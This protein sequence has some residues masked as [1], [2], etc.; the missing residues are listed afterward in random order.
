VANE[1]ELPDCEL[2][3]QLKLKAGERTDTAFDFL[4]TLKAFRKQVAGEVRHIVQ[5]FPEYTPH[6]EE[7]HLTRLFHAADKLLEKKRLTLMNSGELMILALGLYGHD[8][9][10]AVSE[11]QKQC[12]LRGRLV[13]G[14]ELRELWVSHKEV[15]WLENFAH[16]H[17]IAWD[18]Y[19]GFSG[20]DPRLWPEYVR[21]THA[22][23]SGERIRR[24]FEGCDD[25]GLGHQAGR[26]CEAHCLSVEELGHPLMYPDRVGVLDENVNLRAIALYVRLVDLLDLSAGR[27]PYVIWEYVAPRDPRSKIEWEKHRAVHSVTFP[28]GQEGRAVLVEGSTADHEVYAALEDLKRQCEDELRWCNKILDRMKDPRHALQL[29]RVDWSVSAQG[30]DPVSIRFEFDRGAMFDILSQE[31]YQ[32][33]PYVFLRE[34]LQNSVDAIRMRRAVLA[35]HGIATEDFGLVTV[36]V[37]EEHDGEVLVTWRDDGIGMDEHIVRDYLAVAGKSY[38][39]SADFEREDLPMDPIA[40][41]GIGILSCFMVA[42]RVEIETC[43][44]PYFLAS[45]DALR[46][47]IPSTSRQFRVEKIRAK[48]A[49]VGTTVRVFVSEGKLSSPEIDSPRSLRITEYLSAVAGFVEFPISVSEGGCRTIVVHPRA[50]AAAVRKRF[51]PEVEVRQ[52]NTGYDW[53]K[54][55]LP[56]YLQ[57]AER[58]MREVRWDLAADLN[59]AG[60]EGTLSYLVPSEAGADTESASGGDIDVRGIEFVSRGASADSRAVVRWRRPA[61]GRTRRPSVQGSLTSSHGQDHSTYRDGILLWQAP[62]P[63]R[64][65]GFGLEDLPAPRL[66]TN[67][68]RSGSRR[69]DL[70]RSRFVPE[71]HDWDE[72]IADA[73]A[74][75]VVEESISKLLSLAPCDRLYELGRLCLFHRL[76]AKRLWELFPQD[77]WPL[78]FLEHGGQLNALEWQRVRN[79]PIQLCPGLLRFES[80]RLLALRW[81]GLGKYR[82]PLSAWVGDPMLIRSG[83][84]LLQTSHGVERAAALWQFPVKEQYTLSGVRFLNPPWDGDPPLVAKVLSPKSETQEGLGDEAL[85]EQVVHN[86]AD[87]GA[88]QLESLH[89]R[90]IA[91]SLRLGSIPDGATFPAPYEDRFAY[92]SE[93]LNL[94]HPAAVFLLRFV[95]A[96]ELHGRRGVLGA[97]VLAGASD[98]IR[99]AFGALPV[100]RRRHEAWLHEA[101][102]ELVGLSP[103]LALPE[104]PNPEDILVTADDFVPGTA[105]GSASL[106]R[107][108]PGDGRPFGQLIAC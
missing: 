75:R 17:R 22:V 26:V 38:Y 42:D 1:R 96:L 24:F 58:L 19:E 28:A 72:A 49:A 3:N 25:Q 90:T 6:D 7:H 46:I 68:L 4:G 27:A 88:L 9:G 108:R 91:G 37:E 100:H 82:G 101:M 29:H 15:G 51:G 21:E 85:L 67:F 33:D 47:T 77:Y 14:S 36:E 5:V 48:A 81:L 63:H 80:G 73:H 55:F 95:A 62:A 79:D 87:L 45:G 59:V 66:V 78:P 86:P 34:L 13:D 50:D 16:R 99:R 105:R 20:M 65:L 69:V 53:S 32:G 43:M 84:V 8:W 23:R 31:I 44:D 60:C 64:V 2:V 61:G 35:R 41:F 57:S 71:S 12:I 56:A 89:H 39:H 92:G 52:L 97:N 107:D 98:A 30:F 40:R 103:A 102:R 11:R 76:D 54:T 70:A 106:G 74:R 104:I 83:W 94:R 10:M 18:P 93:V